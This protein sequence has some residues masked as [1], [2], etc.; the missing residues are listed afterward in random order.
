MRYRRKGGEV[1]QDGQSCDKT[2]A[3]RHSSGPIRAVGSGV[4]S[5]NSL[6][7]PQTESESDRGCTFYLTFSLSLGKKYCSSFFNQQRISPVI[8]ST[9]PYCGMGEVLVNIYKC[10]SRVNP[11]VE[12]GQ[13]L[14]TRTQQ[15]PSCNIQSHHCHKMLTSP[16]MTQAEAH[17][18]CI[19][20]NP[21]ITESNSVI[22]I[23]IH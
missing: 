15:V 10:S 19:G 16:C 21:D 23:A 20:E 14:L 9:L 1:A 2:E 17:F 13:A 18:I 6:N 12:A 3:A 4:K 5:E 22:F 11:G 7:T 8:Y